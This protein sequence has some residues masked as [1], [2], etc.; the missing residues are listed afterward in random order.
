MAYSFHSLHKVSAWSS[1][2]EKNKTK[3]REI[4]MSRMREGKACKVLFG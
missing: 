2:A 3:E 1:T 4:Q